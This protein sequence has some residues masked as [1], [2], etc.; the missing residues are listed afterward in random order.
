MK[1]K[2]DADYTKLQARRDELMRRFLMAIAHRDDAGSGHVA[3][4][5][6]TQGGE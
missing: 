1:R 5:Y 3:N 6:E 4:V 2:Q